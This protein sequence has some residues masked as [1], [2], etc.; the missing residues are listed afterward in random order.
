LSALLPED[1]IPSGFPK[2]L[3]SIAFSLES[4]L[5]RDSKIAAAAKLDEDYVQRLNAKHDMTK[6]LLLH[7]DLVFNRVLSKL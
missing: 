2:L 7:I 3:V 6:E 4:F 1:I 5:T